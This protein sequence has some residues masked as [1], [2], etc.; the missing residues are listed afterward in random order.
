MQAWLR[1]RGKNVDDARIEGYARLL[2][3]QALIG[4]GSK[5]TDPTAF[6]KRMNDIIA[7]D[8]TT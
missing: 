6:A 8:A 4:E 1:D 2:Y 7:R 3:E 5:L